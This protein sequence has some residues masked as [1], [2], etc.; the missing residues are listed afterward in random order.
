MVQRPSLMSAV[1]RAVSVD[2]PFTHSRRSTRRR[3]M[4]WCRR[5]GYELLR[6]RDAKLFEGPSTW[7]AEERHYRIQIVDADGQRRAAYLTFARQ[8][9][10]LRCTEVLW[11]DPSK[12]TDPVSPDATLHEEDD[13]AGFVPVASLPR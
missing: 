1:V 6:W 11:D 8:L 10:F 9:V 2:V 3:V 4:R 12:A 5:H 7:D 13:A